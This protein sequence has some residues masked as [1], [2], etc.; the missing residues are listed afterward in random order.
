MQV[1]YNRKERMKKENRFS[2]ALKEQFN[3][4]GLAGAGALALATLNPLPL[5]IGIVAEAAYLLFVPDSKWYQSRLALRFDQEVLER[6]E[7]LKTQVFPLVAPDM[8]ERFER[9]EGIRQNLEARAKS[10]NANNA[11]RDSNDDWFRQVL[12]KL[13]YLLEKF[14]LFAKKDAEFRTYVQSVYSSI[15]KKSNYRNPEFDFDYGS[16]SKEGKKVKKLPTDWAQRTVS[17]IQSHYDSEV[18][19]VEEK[20]K[21][22]QDFS[23]QAILDKRVDVLKQRHEYVGKIGRILTNLGHQMELLED[24]FGL[25]NDQMRARTPEQVLGDVDE[26]VTR[27]DA[28]T[29]L[30]DEFGNLEEG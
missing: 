8:Q 1:C 11:N 12:R 18:A 30:L 16:D 14:L 22:E 6:R 17:F 27:T 19:N 13:D 25:I 26:M 28:M 7:R 9:L 21:E 10:D 24:S 2:Q 15:V 20:S 29:Q 3:I 4:L 23:T 5:L